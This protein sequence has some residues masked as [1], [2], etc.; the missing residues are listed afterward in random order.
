MRLY[1]RAVALLDSPE[2]RTALADTV[3]A[4]RAESAASAA[5]AAAAAEGAAAGGG[6]G[7]AAAGPTDDDVDAGGAEPSLHGVP[8]GDSV[9]LKCIQAL[10]VGKYLAL[11]VGLVPSAAGDEDA[12]RK[13]I[14]LME[15]PEPVLAA[16]R[17]RAVA[18]KRSANATAKPGG[19]DEAL[20]AAHMLHD[21]LVCA[22]REY[23]KVEEAVVLTALHGKARAAA[24][25]RKREQEDRMLAV[26]EELA[27]RLQSMS[28][29]EQKACVREIMAKVEVVTA[30]LRRM[31]AAGEDVEAYMDGGDMPFE[32][33]QKPLMQAQMLE[34]M[35]GKAN[36]VQQA[37]R[38]QADVPLCPPCRPRRSQKNK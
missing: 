10:L 30:K 4:G 15:D 37:R 8:C 23:G 19:D 12:L 22:F 16:L 11:L 1:G 26:Q 28:L 2:L 33:E 34:M 32:E 38:S 25:A 24:A 27:D 35:A 6:G 31:D 17:K 36:V 5:A 13:G 3:A 7:G 21:S 9:V 29:A 20:G 14:A 18:E